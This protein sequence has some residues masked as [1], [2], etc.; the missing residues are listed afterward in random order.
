MVAK[1]TARDELRIAIDIEIA[2]RSVL[3]AAIWRMPTYQV[4]E[5]HREL[6]VL[7]DRV[8]DSAFEGTSLQVAPSAPPRHGKTELL[9]IATITRC[10][11]RAWQEG[12]PFAVLY[13]TA[14]DTLARRITRTIRAVLTRLH[15][16]TGDDWFAPD[17][18]GEWTAESLET[19]GGFVMRGIGRGGATGGI[20][21]N[22]ILLDDLIGSK[23]AYRSPAERA[24]I[25]GALEEDFLSRGMDGAS[26]IHMETRRGTEDT[27]AWLQRERGDQWEFHVW[28]CW[29]PERGYLW[30]RRMDDKRRAKLGLT[31]SS[32]TWLSLYQQKPVAEGGTKIAKDWLDATYSEPPQVAASLADHVVIGVDLAATGKTTSDHCAFVVIAIRGAYR[33]VLH[34]Q[35]EQIEYPRQRERLI[36]LVAEWR[37]RAV[38]VERAAG[39][40]GLVAEL[41]ASVSGLRGENPGGQDKVARLSPWLPM[42]AA[43]Q[44]RLPARPEPW[45]RAY[46]EELTAFSGTP[47]EP[48]DQVDAT[49]WALVASQSDGYVSI[50]EWAQLA[51]VR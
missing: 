20:G 11:I 43:R 19:R 45:V 42:M 22:L 18:D 16:E 51:G 28:P 24:A 31:D 3:D 27:T 38:V 37:P 7:C 12:R 39:G 35:R 36:E 32:T 8:V 5:F 26:A 34:V 15:D 48:D 30:A 49:V 41:E 33:D 2:G 29:T 14:K 50:D 23:A 46:R 21:A 17:P 4:V 6:A 9:A 13:V 44:L 10:A 47:G 1:R 25:I 40:A